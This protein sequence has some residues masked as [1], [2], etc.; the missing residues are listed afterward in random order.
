MRARKV[1][2]EGCRVDCGEG[3]GSR[4][5]AGGTKGLVAGGGGG[6]GGGLY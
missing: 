5:I 2:G 6:G 4:R 3:V 1:V